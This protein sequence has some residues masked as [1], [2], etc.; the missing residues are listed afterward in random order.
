MLVVAPEI[1]GAKRWLTAGPLTFQPSELAKL[2]LLIFAAAYLARN[3]A[4]RTLGELWK[5]V[6]MLASRL[7]S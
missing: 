4:P 7:R 6:G 5:P 1:N 3:G 2:A